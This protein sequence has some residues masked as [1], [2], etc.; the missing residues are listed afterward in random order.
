MR[1]GEAGNDRPTGCDLNS[2]VEEIGQGSQEEGDA[3][4]GDQPI[5]E[6]GKERQPEDIK[7]DVVP[8]SEERR[9]G[10]ECR[11]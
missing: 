2:A 8:R 6:E 1:P 7:A 9:V 11:L 10:K 4:R 5:V 3:E